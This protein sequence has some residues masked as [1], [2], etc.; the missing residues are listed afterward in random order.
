MSKEVVKSSK[1]G[2]PD[3]VKAHSA[4]ASLYQQ[5]AQDDMAST[6]Y[7]M[8][9]LLCCSSQHDF[10][11]EEKAKPGQ[12]VD[13]RQLALVADKGVKVPVIPLH[14]YKSFRLYSDETNKDVYVGAL[15]YT[16]ET[17]HH[18]AKSRKGYRIEHTWVD[19][20][21]GKEV[22]KS[23]KC[24][25]AYTFIVALADQ[26]NAVPRTII[27]DKGNAFEG[28][29]WVTAIKENQAIGY[30][31]P[32]FRTYGLFTTL[33]KSN[34]NSWDAFDIVDLKATDDAELTALESPHNWVEMAVKM[35]LRAHETE[36]DDG[37]AANAAEPR[38]SVSE[39]DEF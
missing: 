8:G 25:L 2:V 24:A 4:L 6:D 12:I 17:R 18:E 34:D 21:T 15:D 19:G 29:K 32:F 22:T 5:N 13:N 35:Q 20:L 38:T 30:P 14:W 16:P 10:V 9:R 7:V 23:V 36:V 27:F 33:K 39:K 31:A 28:K 26:P 11:K 3:A 1:G 37:P